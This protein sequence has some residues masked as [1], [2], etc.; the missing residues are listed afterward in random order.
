MGQAIGAVLPLAVAIAIFPVP[1]IASVLLAGAERGLAK[2]GAFVA[3]WF[4]GLL[5]VGIVVLFAADAIEADDGGEPAT[6]VSLLLLALGLACLA[7]AAKGWRGRAR[8]GE[9]APTPGWI[10]AIDRFTVAKSA[11]V[12]VA[13]TAGNPKNL[14]LAA[15]AAVEIAEFGLARRTELAVLVIFALLASAG[16]AAP[17]VL[18]LVL[19]DRS[20]G[21][22]DGLRG[23]LTRSSAAVIAVLLLVIGAKLVGDAISGL[24]A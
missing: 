4:C 6:W 20:R 5:A 8:A 9:E 16:V 10:R 1:V 23:L 15:A 3:A 14:L 2:A 19:G 13:L 18:T 22:L 11:T 12:G 24:S 17:L 7:A 21:V